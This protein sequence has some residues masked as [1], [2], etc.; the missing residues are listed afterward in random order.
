MQ[1]PMKDLLAT[2]FGRFADP[3]QRARGSLECFPDEAGS[4]CPGSFREPLVYRY[5]GN[6]FNIIDSDK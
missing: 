6:P 3:F 5:G 2:Q 1:Q 4:P